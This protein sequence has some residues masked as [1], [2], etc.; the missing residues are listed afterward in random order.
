MPVVRTSW[1]TK[2]ITQQVEEDQPLHRVGCFKLPLEERSQNAD[3]GGYNPMHFNPER[4][5]YAT[6]DMSEHE[7]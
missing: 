5:Q 3:H 7:K 1:I 6:E 2:L 4:R